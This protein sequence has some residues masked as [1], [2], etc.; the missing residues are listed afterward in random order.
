MFK[1]AAAII[2]VGTTFTQRY[3]KKMPEILYSVGYNLFGIYLFYIGL[4]AGLSKPSLTKNCL[5]A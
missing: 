5:I 1:I 2:W 4:A 3:S